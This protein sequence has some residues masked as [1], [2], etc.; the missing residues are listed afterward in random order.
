MQSLQ[1]SMAHRGVGATRTNSRW[2]PYTPPRPTG[3]LASAARPSQAVP[4][5][6]KSLPVPK[7]QSAKA[8]YVASLVD[9][10]VKSLNDIWRPECIPVVFATSTQ[11]SMAKVPPTPPSQR[12]ELR[13][14][15]VYLPSPCSP[16][17]LH[18]PLPSADQSRASIC[19]GEHFGNATIVAEKDLVPIRTF[20]YEVLRR[21]RTTCSVLQSALCYIE[22]IRKKVPELAEKEKQ[23]L[24]V[25]G[26]PELDERIIKED[27][28]A[29]APLNPNDS[30]STANTSG[31]TE[32]MS[33]DP[34]DMSN[35]PTVL[36]TDASQ[37]SCDMLQQL[38]CTL[39][40]RKIPVKPTSPLPPLPSPLLCPRRTFLAALILASKFLQDRC[41]S[42]RAWAKLSG[43]PPREV[44]RC[45]RALGDALEWRL[46]V[47][48]DVSI[49][50]ETSRGIMR[51]KS[52]S[53]ISFASSSSHSQSHMPS[54][55]LSD[56]GASPEF[57][58]VLPS[59]QPTK[60]FN[61][62]LRRAVTLPDESAFTNR[63]QRYRSSA[64][65]PGLASG[66]DPAL[67]YSQELSLAGAFDNEQLSMLDSLTGEWHI[68]V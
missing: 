20:I 3:V 33:M 60:P 23:G 22:A 28:G 26:E 11:I 14:Q 13:R 27:S 44:G 35:V 25:R 50:D 2:H 16:S 30:L 5:I 63:L 17:T 58:R 10:A 59:L 67:W 24:G 61:R 38:N 40:R 52:E 15:S 46:W 6:Q 19:L 65:L 51:T 45:E 29:S 32:L 62:P 55:P 9:Q 21:S 34:S 43:L 64:L 39:K 66:I 36:Q 1:H 41:Y 31:Q 4:R 42:N 12:R 53:T 54:P 37:P 47:G 7:M 68:Q 57:G 56:S 8:N 49:S 18:S 48:K